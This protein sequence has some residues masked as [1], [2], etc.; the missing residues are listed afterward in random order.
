MKMR[1]QYTQTYGQRD[2]SAIALTTL[3]KK[4]ENSHTNQLKVT[5]EGSRKNNNNKC[6]KQTGPGRVDSRKYSNSRLTSINW[7]QRE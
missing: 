4:L 3:I 7:K 2:S 1:A 5:P 6:K